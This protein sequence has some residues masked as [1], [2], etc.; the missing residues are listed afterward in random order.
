MSTGVLGFS[1][2]ILPYIYSLK[3]SFVNLEKH[4]IYGCIISVFILGLS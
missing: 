1:F 2:F 3:L 4:F